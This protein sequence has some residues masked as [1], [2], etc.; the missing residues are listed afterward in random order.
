MRTVEKK[1]NYSSMGVFKLLPTAFALN[2]VRELKAEENDTKKDSS[3]TIFTQMYR[4]PNTT[5]E[6]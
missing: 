2:V 6:I 3:Q 4:I 1:K 5:Q